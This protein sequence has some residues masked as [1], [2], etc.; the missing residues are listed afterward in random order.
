ME[1]DTGMARASARHRPLDGEACCVEFKAQLAAGAGGLAP[2]G[3][4]PRPSGQ[5]DRDPGSFGPDQMAP[6]FDP[7]VCSAPAAAVKHSIWLIAAV[8][9]GT[10]WAVRADEAW[11]AARAR[12]DAAGVSSYAYTYQK[13]CECHREQPSDTIV[14]VEQ[15]RIVD[16]RY[17][18]D[19]YL[20]EVPVPPERYAWFRTVDDLFALV[21]GALERA[22][23]VRVS[24]E[25]R[26]GYP[27]RIFVDYERDLVGE[28]VELRVLQLRELD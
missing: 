28:E 11:D 12:W 2:G 9:M 22:A 15:G 27:T 18:R 5:P 23:M 13:V 16:V 26:L 14:T 19:E 24:Y 21:A 4:A 20:A 10:P 17:D 3:H 1:P 25:P 8:F 6:T 7:L